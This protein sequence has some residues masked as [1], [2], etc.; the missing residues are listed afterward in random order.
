M[1]AKESQES[2]EGKSSESHPARPAG[3]RRRRR[4]PRRRRGFTRRTCSALGRQ[5]FWL[6]R[7]SRN[8]TTELFIRAHELPAWKY[9]S[10]RPE[11]HHDNPCNNNNNN[12]KDKNKN[13]T[14]IT[15]SEQ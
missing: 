6:S 2:P 12:D 8:E 9:E 7:I 4:R 1:H 5:A 3:R 15:T 14:I 13:A 11:Y 10:G